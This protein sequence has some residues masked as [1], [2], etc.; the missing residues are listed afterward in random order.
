MI[1]YSTPN[2]W[3][4]EDTDGDGKADKR[5]PLYEGFG[6]VDTHG[7]SS[8]YIHWLD[9]W[10]YGCH[11]FRNHSEVKDRN[12]KVT[13]FNSGN[14]YRFKPDGS[15]IEY[16]SHGQTNPFGLAFDPLGNLYSADSHSKPVYLLVRGGYYEGIGK[17]HDGLGD[18]P[19]ITDDDHG[20]SAI[21]GVEYYADDKWPVEFH[22]NLFNG[23]P[24]T[25]R[26]NRA[27][28]K[29]Q[30]STPKATREADF[31]SC[32]DPWFR[33]VQAKLG[34]DGALY[35]ADFYNPII[36][37]YEV[38]LTDPRRDRNHGRIWRVVY[39]G[40]NGDRPTPALPDL[41]G[42]DGQALAAKIADSNQTLSILATN[43]LIARSERSDTSVLEG[44]LNW[45]ANEKTSQRMNSVGGLVK[46][47]GAPWSFLSITGGARQAIA[48]LWAL[49]RLG[50]LSD[51]TALAV[52]SNDVV[53]RSHRTRI[54]GE[55]ATVTPD[56]LGELR[57]RASDEDNSVIRTAVDA[58]ARHP[59]AGSIDT[60]LKTYWSTFGQDPE[61]SYATKVALRDTLS[62]PGS[63]AEFGRM[64][65]DGEKSAELIA[66]V[67]LAVQSTDSA[68]FL[69]AHLQ[70]TKL[71]AARSGDYLRHVTLHLPAE[72]IGELSSLLE[73][74]NDL[75]LPQRLPLADALSEAARIRKLELP[76]SLTGWMQ[77]TMIAALDSGDEGVLKRAIQSVRDARMPEKLPAL[78]RIATDTARS[79]SLRIA[80]IES[81]ANLPVASEIL[82]KA[83]QDS[84]SIGLQ[85]RAAELLGP[86]NTDQSRAAL[87]ASL[88]TA[89][90]ELATTIAGA[91]ARSDAG[92][93]LLLVAVESGK[94]SPA[95]LRNKA[96]A[97]PLGG[98]A[99][100]MKDRAARLT[101]ELPPEDDRLD[102]LVA[103][104]T[105]EYGKSK[106]DAPRGQL[107]FQQ[108]CAVCHKVKSIGGN[109]GP[110]LDGVGARGVQ[111][112][113]E[114][115]LDPNRN[116]DPGFRQTLIETADGQMVT[117]ANLREEG[118]AVL[119][120]D[121]TGKE[122]SVAKS[123]IK[124]QVQSRQSLMPPV[125]EQSIAS[126]D[127]A[128][129]LAYLLAHSD[130]GAK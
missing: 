23:N 4:F 50:K 57:K 22:G 70:R 90:W 104:R 98:R 11:G 126:P 62:A 59:D 25:Q 29:W 7:M 86:G 67:S 114:D 37:H 112:L 71:R 68:A 73:G 8:N 61:L 88:M 40:A 116:V 3:R 41:S 30:G 69:Q 75:S 13:V 94:A 109:V 122:L 20:S 46:D 117:G 15:K 99:P 36:G 10:I 123:A 63:Y 9:G 28:L 80:A 97:E 121:A 72:R 82:I 85:K 74:A 83:L 55:R 125:F 21:A 31:L 43:E 128:D 27:S 19:R 105:A 95:L 14:T 5:E 44:L 66:D 17:Q 89:P 47:R 130:G 118:G 52:E 101:S 45:E 60:L 26:I 124:T 96:V 113:I 87:L 79:G 108:Q 49:E 54:L 12:G 65:G 103:Q 102:Q 53:V 106:A 111:R 58:L 77:L 127:F 35:I 1:A 92:A 56:L 119:L 6:F 110:N 33:P 18:A 100:S 76:Q 91:L 84:D 93:E 78:S 115:I 24:V 64:A 34:P 129:L 16:W 38:P 81:A 120:T 39:R 32:D 107:V 42:L 48:G 2:I 51:K